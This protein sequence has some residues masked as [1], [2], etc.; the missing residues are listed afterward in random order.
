MDEEQLVEL[1]RYSS[2]K[3]LYIIAWN[4]LL[5]VL[6]CPFKVEVL[7]SVGHLKKGKIVWVEEVKITR[8]LVTVYVIC[9]EAYYYYYFDIVG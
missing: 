8:E 4:D 6:F 2:P 7:C 1:L 3:E 5:K 9:A